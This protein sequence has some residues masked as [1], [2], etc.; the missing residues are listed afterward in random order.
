MTTMQNNG[1]PAPKQNWPSLVF[2]RTLSSHVPALRALRLWRSLKV[3]DFDRPVEDALPSADIVTIC[4]AQFYHL[5]FILSGVTSLQKDLG[6]LADMAFW[7][8]LWIRFILGEFQKACSQRLQAIIEM[9]IFWVQVKWP[10]SSWC[11]KTWRSPTLLWE[12][13]ESIENEILLLETF[14]F[15]VNACSLWLYAFWS[16][17]FLALTETS[18]FF[19]TRAPCIFHLANAKGWNLARMSAIHTSSTSIWN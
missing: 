6:L 1:Y 10:E 18:S 9:N 14:S 11:L 7:Y 19:Y 12:V 15:S 13:F 2:L 17:C 8:M 4:A 3:R 5:I 16:F